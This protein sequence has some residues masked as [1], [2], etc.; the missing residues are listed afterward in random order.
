MKMSNSVLNASKKSNKNPGDG[1]ASPITAWAVEI[2][3]KIHPNICTTRATARHIRRLKSKSG[4]VAVHVR[5]V[6]IQVV[7]GAR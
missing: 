3:G 5:K 1:I 2:D 4:T 6:T 7:P